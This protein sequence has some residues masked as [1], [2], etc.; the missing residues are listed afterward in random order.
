MSIRRVSVRYDRREDEWL[1]RCD[2]CASSGQ[3]KAYW[4]LTLEFWD[5][6]SGLQQCRACHNLAKRLR[7]QQTVEE[8]RAKVRAYYWEHREHRL[9]WRRENYAKRREE[10]NAKR[11]AEYAAKKAAALRGPESIWDLADG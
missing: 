9:A 5:P 11:R 7:R 8:R 3:T 10:I 1:M 6:R 2:S 4:P